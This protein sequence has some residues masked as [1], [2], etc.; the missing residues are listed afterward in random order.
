MGSGVGGPARTM[1]SFTGCSVTGIN[2]NKYQIGRAREHDKRMGLSHLVSYTEGDFMNMPFEDG[3]F[4]AAYAFEALCHAANKEGVFGEAFRVLKPGGLFAACDWCMTMRY[5]RED[6]DERIIKK[7]IEEGDGVPNLDYT[8]DVVK[9]LKNVGFEV[10]EFEDMAENPEHGSIP[11]YQPLQGSLSLDGFRHT[12]LGRSLT[13]VFVSTLEWVGI[14]PAG[15]TEVSGVLMKAAAN[16]VAGGQRHIFTPIFYWLARKPETSAAQVAA[17][18]AAAAAPARR[19]RS[20][21][22]SRRK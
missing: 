7:N 5:N 19:A 16:L 14:A 22:P 6:A 8:D 15:S 11:W 12:W 20:R 18:A 3:V 21:S 9:A 2:T 1:A 17:A 4:D 13:H 10:L